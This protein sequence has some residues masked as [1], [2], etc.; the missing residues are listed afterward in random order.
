M[1]SRCIYG[2]LGLFKE[3]TEVINRKG[4]DAE[5]RHR[6]PNAI[7]DERVCMTSDTEIGQHTHIL[8]NVTLN[9]VKIASY[10]YIG[11]DCIFQ[12]TSI[13]SYCS[14]S[15]D[16]L[17]GLGDHPL[18]GFSTSP[19]FYRKDNTFKLEVVQ[20][21]SEFKE[22]KQIVIGNDVWIGARA[23]IKDGVTIGHGAVI[24]AGAVVTKDVPAYAIVAGVPARVI[25]YRTSEDKIKK[26]LNTEWWD[27]IPTD[28]MKK[29]QC[30]DLL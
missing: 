29:M 27:E 9:H 22:Y 2:T 16:V 8:C 17:C 5:N 21:N 13:G 4:R 11:E 23:I 15:R 3:L 28:A 20:S 19:L 12:N 6:F 30:H 14:I 1:I 18:N 10:S 25:R 24:A 26:L 7:I